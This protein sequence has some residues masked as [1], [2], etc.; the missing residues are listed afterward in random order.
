MRLKMKRFAFYSLIRFGRVVTGA[1][2]C[3]HF[4]ARHMGLLARWPVCS[5]PNGVV[6]CEL[7]LVSRRNK[8]RPS[9]K[10]HFEI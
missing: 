1:R 3:G 2:E 10:W 7:L 4:A 8:L 6:S 5:W 9:L